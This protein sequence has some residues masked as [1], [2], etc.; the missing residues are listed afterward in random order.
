MRYLRIKKK[1]EPL[2][3]KVYNG[4]NNAC[5]CF[6]TLF[7][8]RIQYY[9]FSIAVKTE[10]GKVELR[11]IWFLHQAAVLLYIENHSL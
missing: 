6:E 7:I 5:L 11:E 8:K 9:Y 4:G 2:N 1:S 3:Q 10:K